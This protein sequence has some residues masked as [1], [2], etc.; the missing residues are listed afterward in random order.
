MTATTIIEARAKKHAERLFY[1]LR[2][3]L[4]DTQHKG[5][6]CGQGACPVAEARAVL[7]L[8]EGSVD[9]P[10]GKL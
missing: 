1:A 7:R 4:E 10:E 2:E 6:N 5:H 3:L 8:V 9:Q